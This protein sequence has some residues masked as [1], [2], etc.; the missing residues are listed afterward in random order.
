MAES[1]LRRTF[2]TGELFGGYVIAGGGSG[3]YHS[4][5]EARDAGFDYMR[6]FI[7]NGEQRL[8]AETW[9]GYMQ[10]KWKNDAYNVNTTNGTSAKYGTG[11]QTTGLTF[12]DA[13]LGAAVTFFLLLC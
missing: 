1:I 11:F 8:T 4:S 12:A 6:M 2:E 13:N 9:N 7:S 3:E 5:E 10:A